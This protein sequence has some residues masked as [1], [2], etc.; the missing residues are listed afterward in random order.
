VTGSV[1]R[2]PLEKLASLAL[3]IIAAGGIAALLYIGHA[4]FVPVAFAVLFALI[5]SSPV[6]A[7]HRYGIPRS[8][9][10]TLILI[11][12]IGVVGGTLHAVWAPARA[13]I[14]AIPH[15]IEII[16]HKIGP[17][18]QALEHRYAA[19]NPTHPADRPALL[20]A[21]EF[22]MNASGSL[23]AATPTIA[24]NVVTILILTLFLVS[25]GAPMTARLAG[26][27]IS[28]G[29]SVKVLQVI[30]AL[31]SEVARYYATVALINLGLGTATA[32]MTML[33]QLPSPLLWGTMAMVLNFLPYVGSTLTLL[34]LTVVSIVTFDSIAHVVAV[35]ASFLVL[36][37]IEGQ[38]VEP[39]LIGRRLKLSPTIVFLALWF[40]GWFW[41][42]SGIFL[43]IPFL[44]SLK[45][46]AEHT[47]NGRILVDLLSPAPRKRLELVSERAVLAARRG[48]VHNEP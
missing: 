11:C 8:L 15:T 19:Q 14:T 22:E 1:G 17:V 26:T 16:E 31:R 32:A 5:L 6:E 47:P 39:L 7:L 43:A 42:I 10:A 48:D 29:K 9:G 13:W 4:A 21:E 18:A 38:I 20:L 46:V 37:T 30:G 45:V 35:M 36:V 25:G 44:V 12:I 28:N 33:L 2:S 3:V 40:G 34:V 23:L 24:A 41:G 27:L